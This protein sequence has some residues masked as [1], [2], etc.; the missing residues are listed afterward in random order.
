MRRCLMIGAVALSVMVAQDSAAQDSREDCQ[1]F[2]EKFRSI[3]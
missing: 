1:R 3:E 2:I